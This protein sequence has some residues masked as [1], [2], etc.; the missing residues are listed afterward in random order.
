MPVSGAKQVIYMLKNARGTVLALP[1]R[2]RGAMYMAPFWCHATFLLSLTLTRTSTPHQVV[3]D[4]LCALMCVLVHA[5]ACL[6]MPVHACARLCTP[7]H[8]LCVP[9][10]GLCDTCTPTV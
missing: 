6:C 10:H 3:N 9:V 4:S 7:V 2:R 5:C 1:W 8:L